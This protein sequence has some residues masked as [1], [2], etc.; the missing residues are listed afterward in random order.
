MIVLSSNWPFA[1]P[2]FS[3]LSVVINS[4]QTIAISNLNCI[5]LFFF[6]FFLFLHASVFIHRNGKCQRS[7][8]CDFHGN[9]SDRNRI[10][11]RVCFSFM[12]MYD[13]DDRDHFTLPPPLPPSLQ[14]TTILI[15]RLLRILWSFR[16][17]FAKDLTGLRPVMTS[18]M[19][20]SLWSIVK[21]VTRIDPP[22]VAIFSTLLIV[23]FVREAICIRSSC[24]R[25]RLM[26]VGTEEIRASLNLEWDWKPIRISRLFYRPLWINRRTYE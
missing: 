21:K 6:F 14:F 4:Q 24:E 16:D 25:G 22:S 13:C 9:R 18:V 3:Y 20:F 8:T 11:L 15:H 10:V 19:L 26:G 12:L 7:A 1:S 5:S 2:N 17:K 23:P